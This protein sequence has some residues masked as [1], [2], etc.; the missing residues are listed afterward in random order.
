MADEIARV[1]NIYNWKQR[2]IQM[3]FNYRLLKPTEVGPLLVGP[4]RYKRL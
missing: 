4:A 3:N 2:H 1:V